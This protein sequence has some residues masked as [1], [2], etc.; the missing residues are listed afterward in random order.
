MKKTIIMVALIFLLVNSFSVLAGQINLSIETTTLDDQPQDTFMVGE[1]LKVN[2][3]VNDSGYNLNDAYLL[4]EIVNPD[5]IGF[6][7]GGVNGEIYPDPVEMELYPK[8][9]NNVICPDCGWAFK[10]VSLQSLIPGVNNKRLLFT[11][12]A[13]TKSVGIS[14]AMVADP[15]TQFVGHTFIVPTSTKIVVNPCKL[16]T[17]KIVAESG[18]EV[19]GIIY[20]GCGGIEDCG[21]CSGGK[22]CVEGYCKFITTSDS[23]NEKAQL[24]KFSLASQPNKSLLE[25]LLNIITNQN[26]S[27]LQKLSAIATALKT[28]FNI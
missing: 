18:A 6:V 9:I 24:D 14:Y 5:V 21:S 27:L 10:K 20:D 12:I 16:T 23:A 1:K 15:P 17:C 28:Y 8:L 22:T 11:A 4:M 2:V 7:D 3:Y 13:K 25:N 19:C 26:A